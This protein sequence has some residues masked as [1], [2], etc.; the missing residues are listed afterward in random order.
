MRLLSTKPGNDVPQLEEF[1][2]EEN[3]P[4]YIILSHTWE[5][6][7]VSLQDLRDPAQ[8]TAKQGFQ[9]IQRTCALAARNGFGFTW[10][11]TC[12]IDKQ[13]S[14]E[15]SEAINSMFRW[16]EK[17][18]VCYAFLSDLAPKDADADLSSALHKCRWFTRGWTLQEL[19]APVEVWFYDRDWNYRG[20]RS[21]LADTISAIT[22]IPV[23]LLRHEASLSDFSV[24]CRIH[25]YSLIGIFDVHMSLVYGERL[26]AFSRLQEAVLQTTGDHRRPQHPRLDRRQPRSTTVHRIPR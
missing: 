25:A 21:D 15:L 11:D 22:N 3:F 20:T 12:C 5:D 4:P 26:K 14:A 13:A 24:A 10:V 6:G 1:I 2:G 8:R 7:E 23:P 16:Y 18:S 17:A 9:K 19:I